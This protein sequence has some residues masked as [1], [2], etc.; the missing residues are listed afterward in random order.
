M[1][2]ISTRH[3]IRSNYLTLLFIL[4]STVHLIVADQDEANRKIPYVI[5][6]GS[7]F[8]KRGFSSSRLFNRQN[9]RKNAFDLSKE[10]RHQLNVIY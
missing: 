2:L 9:G 6:N 8:G 5:P 3:H 1:F 7:I 10:R 4:F